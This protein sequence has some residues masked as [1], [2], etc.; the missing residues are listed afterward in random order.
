[1]RL[2]SVL[3][4]AAAVMAFALAAPVPA[5]AFGDEHRSNFKVGSPADP[6]SYV[7]ALPRYYPYV[8]SGYWVPAEQMRGRYRYRYTLPPY[9]QSWGWNSRAWYLAH[10]HDR[11]WHHLH[12]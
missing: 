8:N 7:P 11:R 9:Q 6:Y 12:R 1:M 5:E 2:K 3:A 4:A 10:R